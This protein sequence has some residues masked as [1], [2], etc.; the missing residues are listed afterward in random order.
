MVIGSFGDFTFSVHERGGAVTFNALSETT[1]SRLATHATIEGLPIVEFLGVDAENIKISGVLSAEISG[2]LD[3]IVLQLKALQDGQPRVLTRGD[4]VYGQFVVKSLSI[5]EDAW[6][7]S[8][9]AS[10]TY[11]LDLIATR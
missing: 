8:A 9:L 6:R 11:T 2:D 1:A 5:S 10:I 7:G 4:R 3:D